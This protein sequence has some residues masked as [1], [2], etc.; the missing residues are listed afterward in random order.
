MDALRCF[1]LGMLLFPFALHGQYSRERVSLVLRGEEALQRQEVGAAIDA[2]R[3]AARDTSV[4]RRAAA[5]RM[6]G[7]ISWRFYHENGRAREHFGAALATQHDTAAT[8]VELGRLAISEGRYRQAFTFADRARAAAVDDIARRGAVLQMA[9]AVTEAALAARV[10]DAPSA[11]HADSAA[12]AS[13]VSELLA[14]VRE[15]PGRGD[16]SHQLLLAALIAGDGA[17]ATSGA[18]SYYLVNV[19]DASIQT[20]IPATIAELDKLLPAWHGDH[21]RV[22]GRAKI[23][24]QLGQRRVVAALVGCPAAGVDLVEMVEVG[25]E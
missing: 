20:A 5:E 16:E 10:D 1:G 24:K 3:A 22:Q 18:D 25:S 13:V 6:L 19:G 7:I 4:A 17:A 11:D 14:L 12:V 15:T 8:L 23:I 21:T 2:F 9:R